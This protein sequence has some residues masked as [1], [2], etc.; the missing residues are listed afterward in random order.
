M[1]DW[2]PCCSLMAIAPMPDIYAAE[3]K[4]Y[5]LFFDITRL[6]QPKTLMPPGELP[7]VF[8][9][10]REGRIDAALF[11]LRESDAAPLV[12]LPPGKSAHVS[13]TESVPEAIRVLFNRGSHAKDTLYVL[14]EARLLR[15][16]G[17]HAFHAPTQHFPLHLRIIHED[18][19]ER[20]AAD[21]TE[22]ARR[23]LARLLKHNA[24]RVRAA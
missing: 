4:S 3:C 23:S 7:L 21:V 17:Y 6:L 5:T 11:L 10:N 15:A 8:V 24:R 13:F 2:L 12:G 16:T 9:G 14:P 20:Q 18:M 19:I 1:E 22:S